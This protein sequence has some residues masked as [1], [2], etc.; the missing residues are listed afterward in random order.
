MVPD[1]ERTIRAQMSFIPMTYSNW[2]QFFTCFPNITHFIF[3][4]S[5]FV[6][7]AF[8]FIPECVAYLKISLTKNQVLDLKKLLTN[9]FDGVFVDFIFI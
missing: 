2:Q 1:R 8:E 9:R 7:N 5:G 6:Q 3:T 4:G